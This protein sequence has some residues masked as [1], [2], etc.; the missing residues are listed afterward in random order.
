MENLIGRYQSILIRPDQ[1]CLGTQASLCKMKINLGV[2]CALE[3]NVLHISHNTNHATDCRLRPEPAIQ[4]NL[5][6]QGVL[7]RPEDAG[8]GGTNHYHAGR[9]MPVVIA[10]C[11]SRDDGD[12][13][14]PEVVCTDC[15]SEERRVGKEC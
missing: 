7:I 3:K 13:Q 8:Q 6:V 9:I 12:L 14:G 2:P 15:R 10:E 5:P 11:T 1:H 4:I